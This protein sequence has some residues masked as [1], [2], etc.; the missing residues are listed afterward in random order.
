MAMPFQPPSLADS[1]APW[2]TGIDWPILAAYLLLA[3]GLPL[4]GY[5]GLALDIRAYLRSLRQRALVLVSNFRPE[6]P[7]WVRRGT[8][9][10]IQALGLTMPCTA[11][12]V[13]SA[14][15]G[16]VKQLHP[17]RGGNRRDFLRLQAHFEE[18]MAL[19]RDE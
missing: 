12:D 7:E 3:L 11:E 2:P 9:R 4:L 18:A 15:R 6:L 17:D 8:P 10:C 19:V 14:Y 1:A 5:V 13:L 16:K